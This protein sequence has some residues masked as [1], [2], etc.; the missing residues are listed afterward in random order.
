MKSIEVDR[1]N[2]DAQTITIISDGDFTKEMAIQSLG[3]KAEEFVVV[4][5]TSK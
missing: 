3:P 5:V 4:E 2:K 1:A